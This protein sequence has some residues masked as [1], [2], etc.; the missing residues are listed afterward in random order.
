MEF[1]KTFPAQISA[2]AKKISMNIYFC[3]FPAQDGERSVLANHIDFVG[4]ISDG[5]L[6]IYNE[7]HE[8]NYFFISGGIAKMKQNHFF[9]VTE[10]L[11]LPSNIKKEEIE[12]LL[13]SHSKKRVTE[14]Y[15]FEK[16]QKDIQS[17]KS[18]LKILEKI[19]KL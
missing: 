11:I 8:L 9:I 18:M 14:S 16:K 13:E 15:T 19:G 6:K 12:K 7:K 4:L 10:K 1:T 3:N 17:A 5:I 2:P